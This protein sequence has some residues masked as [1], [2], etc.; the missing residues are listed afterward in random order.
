MISRSQHN[1]YFNF[2]IRSAVNVSGVRTMLISRVRDKKS[3]I[4]QRYHLRQTEATLFGL[5][6]ARAPYFKQRS[7]G[8]LS[9]PIL[10]IHSRLYLGLSRARSEDKSSGE[11]L[12]P[13]P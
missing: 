9:L 13:R 11:P 12:S 7:D 10:R 8:P 5:I 4:C 6:R 3:E 2:S 1:V